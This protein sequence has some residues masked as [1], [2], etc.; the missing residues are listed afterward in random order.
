M[1][2]SVNLIQ[3]FTRVLRALLTR[4]RSQYA[5]LLVFSGMLLAD[6]LFRVYIFPLYS[7]FL[8]NNG[9]S[10]AWTELD[11]GFAPIVWLSFF[12]II[13]GSL[14]IVIT[15]ASQNVPK[16]IDLYMDHWA[17][18]FFVWW[19][20]A[21]LIHAF[22]I[23]ILAETGVDIVASLVFNYHILLAVS[24][25]IG[26]PFIF[27][28]LRSTKTSNVIENLLQGSYRL[29]ENLA[30]KGPKVK[31][32]EKAHANIQYQLFEELNQLMDLL[33]YVPY[34][35]PK[36]HIIEGIGALLQKYVILKPNFPE[37]FFKVNECIHEDISFRTMKN[38]LHD[39]EKK[40]TFYEQK[41]FRLI[42]NVYNVFL[43]T[44]EFD[45][46]TLCVEQ[47]SQIGK[48][49][50][51]CDDQAVVEEVTVRMNTYFRFA[52]KHGQH[53]NEPR[54]L[55]NLVFHYGRFLEDLAEYQQIEKIKTCI[56]YFVFYGQQCF[57][58]I[59]RARSLAFILDVLAF[60]MQ[61]LML[62][63]YQNNWDRELQGEL[64]QKFLIFDNFQDMDKNFAVQFFSQNHGIRL[65]HIGLALF[66]L[67]QHEDE[68]A[69]A[70]A[71]DTV[72]DLILM[73]E[74]L[75][76]KT[77]TTIYARLQFSGPKFW[78]DTDRG[79]INIYYTPYQNEIETFKKL[80]QKYIL[81]SP[82]KISA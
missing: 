39:V 82:T 68:F 14:T 1:R 57:N 71:K 24:L 58:A 29:L 47:L 3:G 13:L 26:F 33:V 63:I 43:D 62:N 9:A 8:I 30:K 74:P 12:A 61:K 27:T 34:K 65:L 2:E 5:A 45:L 23:K 81:E 25:V 48:T 42:G 20:V 70:I 22:T 41:S 50:I 37:L 38:L 28:I 59:P 53:H 36:A 78:E 67:H 55:Y 44:G 40:H 60:E 16:L 18:L 66:Y 17:S 54:N 6:T 79:N 77:M 52:L 21:C 69:E 80:Q 15:F 76:K 10:P 73:G 49:A 35:E 11:V 51:A 75:F 46:S 32:S 19:A 72:Q 64:L 7:K 56:G 31:L 4:S